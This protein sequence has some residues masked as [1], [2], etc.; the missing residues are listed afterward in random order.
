MLSRSAVL[1]S[2]L[3]LVASGA[4]AQPLQTRW[5]AAGD[6][7][8]WYADIGS[9]PEMGLVRVQQ[10][11][12]R[13]PGIYALRDAQV[14]KALWIGAENVTAEDGTAYPA[15]VVHVGPRVSGREGFF[16]TR[17]E[18]VTR[19]AMP[20][21]RVDGNPSLPEA[22]MRPDAVDPDLAPE[23][24]IVNEVNTLLGVTMRRTVMQF[25][26][27]HHDD[28][29][30]S[31]YVFTNTGNTDADAE[32]ER[33]NQTLTG[34]TF[35]FQ[36]RLAIARETRF[37]IG[38]P[39]GWGK[40]T[41]LDARGDGV[42]ADPEDERFRAQ[43]A[44]HGYVPGFTDY[45]NIG[46]PILPEAL[47]A[48]QIAAGDTL[49]RLGASQ[50]V[51]TVTLHADRA[52]GDATDDSGQPSTMTWQGSDATFQSN[53]SPFD[54]AQ[55]EVEYAVMT[56]GR[57][58]PR[59]AWAVEPTGMPGW[60]NP[61]NNP[62]LGTSG[63]HTPGEGYGPYTLAPGESVRIVVAEAVG[64]LSREADVAL[65][66]AWLASGADPNAPLTF[67]GHTMT[68]N[69][70]VFTSRDSLF[71]T[72]RRALANHA[73]GYAIPRAPAPPQSFTV[74]SA[75][76]GD[77]G[78]TR[79]VRL[80]WTPP[81]DARGLAGYEIYRASG[82]ADSVH[83]LIHTAPPE[84]TSYDDVDAPAGGRYVYH[85]LSVGRAEDND[86]TARHAAGCAP[87]QPLLHADLQPHE[88]R[89]GCRRAWPGALALCPPRAGPQPRQRLGRG[90]LRP[91]DR[92]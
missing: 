57:R 70:W 18:L 8:N 32:I 85:I 1:L 88:R 45:N 22:L 77:D 19:F 6:L 51:G 60:L 25:A 33:P 83:T 5:L 74:T 2:F 9:E 35:F 49:G 62:S 13:W 66:R 28:Y 48:S 68:K 63:G 58:T 42:R 23:A 75:G 55:M 80:A 50:F 34:L 31:E 39:T 67:G 86:G 84:A 4:V 92:L 38:N 12:W 71:Q 37:V 91:R 24:M 54:A 15:R 61:T 30:V 36:R 26:Q 52:S 81:A 43:F 17:F 90:P 73:S 78:F 16:P 27:A 20:D 41:M 65:G 79:P 82:V 76:V 7:H 56:S 11:G 3:A 53:N 40:N 14:A 64:G 69:E 46:G 72:F 87:Q 59:H 89:S 47:P 10:Y 21:V 29:H 44:W